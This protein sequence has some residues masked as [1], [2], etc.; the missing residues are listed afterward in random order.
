M[1]TLST[2]AKMD[3]HILNSN[4]QYTLI[5]EKNYSEWW[6]DLIE[7]RTGKAQTLILKTKKDAMQYKKIDLNKIKRVMDRIGIDS[8]KAYKKITTKC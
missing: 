7:K 4:A 2:I 8:H 5:A 6:L 3:I 1:T